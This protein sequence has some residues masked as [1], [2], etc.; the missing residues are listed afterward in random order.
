MNEERDPV[1]ESLFVQAER[2]LI[3]EQF[4]S[5]VMAGIDRRRR[6]MLIGRLAAIGLL[7]MLELLLNAPI[8]NSVGT[9]AGTLG[10]GLLQLDN[11]WAAYALGPINSIAGLIG[12]TLL[13]L[14][15]LFRKVLR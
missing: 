11:E 5:R 8:Q 1:L 4:T 3:D 12:M 6:N 9:V 10:S 14:N 7:V 15:F 2:E 13:G